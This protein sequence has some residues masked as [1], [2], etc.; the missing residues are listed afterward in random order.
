MIIYS[1]VALF[2][3]DT[4][5]LVYGNKS[6]QHVYTYLIFNPSQLCSVNSFIKVKEITNVKCIKTYLL[7]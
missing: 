7:A 6:D 5:T 2:E 3:P 1:Q 4:R